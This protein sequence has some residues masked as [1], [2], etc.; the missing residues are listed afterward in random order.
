[1][2]FIRAVPTTDDT[3]ASRTRRRLI[4]ATT[5]CS[6]TVSRTASLTCTSQLL[7]E[8]PDS[9]PYDPTRRKSYLAFQA[10]HAL[11]CRVRTESGDCNS[12][13]H[14]ATATATRRHNQANPVT[15][16]GY[17]PTFDLWSTAA[18][19]TAADPANRPNSVDQK[20][21]SALS[22]ARRLTQTPYNF[23][24]G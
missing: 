1:M 20:L 15:P 24:D 4:S 13:I 23:A 14:S 12:A 8:R 21:V 5:R 10:E 19:T 6:V 9:R 2:E 22:H 7:A 3:D 17:N 18:L 11:T 16:K